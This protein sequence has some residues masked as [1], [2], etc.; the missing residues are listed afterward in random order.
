MFWYD[1]GIFFIIGW[2]ALMILHNNWLIAK[3]GITAMHLGRILAAA[4]DFFMWG[5]IIHAEKFS[6]VLLVFIVLAALILLMIFAVNFSECQSIFHAIMMTI[7]QF[8]CGFMIFW[9][10]FGVSNSRKEKKQD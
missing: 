8:T 7:F 10:I 6:V 5:T 3:Y 9:M 2:L 4:L 1:N